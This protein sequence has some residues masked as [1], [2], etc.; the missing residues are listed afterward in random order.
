MEYTREEPSDRLDVQKEAGGNA[1]EGNLDVDFNEG[2][3]VSDRTRED[4]LNFSE[5][6]KRD[7]QGGRDGVELV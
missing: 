4:L 3:D 7:F 2:L 6:V 5:E 1:R